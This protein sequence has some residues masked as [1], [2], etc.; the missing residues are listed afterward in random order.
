M[1]MTMT[2]ATIITVT[3]M[4]EREAAKRN[5][6]NTHPSRALGMAR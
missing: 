5:I 2:T 4:T 1:M 3:T 6:T